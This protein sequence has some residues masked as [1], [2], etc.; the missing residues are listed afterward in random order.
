MALD[1]LLS[2]PNAD[3]VPVS[4]GVSGECLSCM[5]PQSAPSS[6]DCHYGDLKAPDI[7]ISLLGGQLF[8]S[9]LGLIFKGLTCML[10]DVYASMYGISQ[11]L[12]SEPQ[13]QLTAVINITELWGIFTILL[14]GM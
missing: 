9:K 2:L 14:A 6:Y 3:T 5:L 1:V 12:S 4:S 13:N 11:L 7:T 10:G 8:S